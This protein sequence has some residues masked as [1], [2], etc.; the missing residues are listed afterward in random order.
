MGWNTQGQVGLA[1]LAVFP[2][3]FQTT[4]NSLLAA[5]GEGPRDSQEVGR[6]LGEIVEL[7][8]NILSYAVGQRDEA[9]ALS[10]TV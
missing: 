7:R 6:S 4:G 5:R 9:S 3:N 10:A 8:D 2:D 1:L